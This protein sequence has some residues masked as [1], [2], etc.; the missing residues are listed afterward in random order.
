MYCKELKLICLTRWE[1]R[2]GK[3]NHEWKILIFQDSVVAFLPSYEVN[4]E[5]SMRQA[6]EG[7][8][9]WNESICN[10]ISLCHSWQQNT[11]IK[12]QLEKV[13]N[14][15]NIPK[16]LGKMSWSKGWKGEEWVIVK[17]EQKWQK[18]LQMNVDKQL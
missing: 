13:E 17:D 16:K 12:E 8:K 10:Y 7:R 2:R 11:K 6:L 9:T 18:Y 1:G 15:I 5:L 4:E 14:E 3:E